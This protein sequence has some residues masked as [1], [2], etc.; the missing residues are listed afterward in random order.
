MNKY[1]FIFALIL[2]PYSAISQVGIGTTTPD[3]SAILD[4]SSTTGG[5]LLPR[6]NEVERDGI[7]NPAIGLLIYFI[8]GN[9]QCLQVYNGSSWE[10]IYCPTTNTVPSA[11]NVSVSGTLNVSEI[12]TAT[13][14]YQDAESDIEDVSLY[15][16]YRS[17][18]ASGTNEIA[19]TGATSLNYTV[20][21]SDDGK[22]LS[23]GVTPIAVTGA[24]T[25]LE[26]KSNYVG[27][28]GVVSNATARINEFHYD[29]AGTDVN[30]FVE[31]RISGNLG[32]QPADLSQYMVSLYNG[33]DQSFYL[34]V[35]LDS[36]TQTCD[37]S[38]CYYVLDSIAIQNGAP[39]GIAL[40]SPSG[41]VEF[42]SYEGTFTASNGIASGVLSVNVGVF[43]NGNGDANGAIER[44]VA[45]VWSVSTNSNSKGSE[46]SL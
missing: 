35:T 37:A 4:V 33:S 46:N 16:W 12:I 27:A 29:N 44:S 28:V 18:D 1:L 32:S 10:N 14:A 19:I 6:M 8:E 7:S 36:L 24:L 41:L 17:D 22:Y 40:S 26:V 43:E 2:C 20:S 15:Q 9:Q 30:E 34:T 39:D 23:F 5:L 45:G 3:Q 13:Y 42:V 25:G 38:N 11:T 31:I 21:V